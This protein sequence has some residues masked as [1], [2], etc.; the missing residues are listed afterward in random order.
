MTSERPETASKSSVNPDVGQLITGQPMP[1]LLPDKSIGIG[2]RVRRVDYQSVVRKQ[3]S[4][5]V[6][7]QFEFYFAGLV[8]M[9]ARPKDSVPIAK[10]N[11]SCPPV[12]GSAKPA[13]TMAGINGMSKAK[14]PVAKQTV[15][16]T[17]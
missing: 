9:A 4:R 7:G 17:W 12:T 13:S 3:H 6:V 16:Q 14:I 5:L 11:V 2:F 15:T 8:A 10:W 1:T